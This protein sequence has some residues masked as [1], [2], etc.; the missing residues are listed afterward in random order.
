VCVRACVRVCV[1]VYIYMYI[2]MYIYIYSAKSPRQVS[3]YKVETV[4]CLCDKS[5]EITPGISIFS[6][7]VIFANLF[8]F[9][10]VLRLHI[11]C[12]VY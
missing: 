12:E 11:F 1:C 8:F 9:G 7:Y 5:T 2:Y 3:V 10:L 4:T 6:D